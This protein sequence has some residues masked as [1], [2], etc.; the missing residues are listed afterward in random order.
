MR[1]KQFKGFLFGI[2]VASLA[3]QVDVD[4]IHSKNSVALIDFIT[5]AE[6]VISPST[7]CLVK[8]QHVQ[9]NDDGK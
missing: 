7:Q 8:V 2:A 3:F 9:I 6:M 4:L 1:V 5:T